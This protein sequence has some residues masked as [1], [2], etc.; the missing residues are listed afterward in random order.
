MSLR[1]IRILE[2]GLLA[3]VQDR[4]RFGF[5]S[6]GVP[7]SGAMD[8]QALRVGNLLVGNDDTLAAVEITMGGFSAEF[9]CG[10]SFAL[11]GAACGAC[12][13]GK[14]IA[15]WQAHGAKAGDVLSISDVPV[16]D[17]R[18]RSAQSPAKGRC[19]D[20]DDGCGFR[21]YLCISGGID[22][23]PVM[24]SRSTYL[25]GGFG[26]LDGR[27][28]MA[29]DTLPLGHPG[30]KAMENPA[31]AELI[32]RYSH[33]P[34][35]RAIPGPQDDRVSDLGKVTFF[36][37]LFKVTHRADRMGVALSGPPLELVGGAD[38]IS[39][40]TCPGAVQV[41]G[42]LQPTILVADCQTAG[43]YVKIATVISAD[44]PLVAQLVPGDRVGF[45]EISLWRAREIYLRNEHLLRSFS[46]WTPGA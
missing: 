44:L 22:L 12:L 33:R 30:G 36:S 38:I 35:L 3:T 34:V 46:K 8:L 21:I 16:S 28:L 1:S 39:D 43:G 29:G 15:L 40:G 27:G 17:E 45:E 9:R 26:G 13:N 6:M 32:P 24:G 7:L 41:D 20:F 25:R 23:A 42:S 19:D 5:R 11:S 2:P 37:R 14:K 31:P 18:R 10:V 4:G